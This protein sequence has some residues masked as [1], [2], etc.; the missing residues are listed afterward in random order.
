MAEVRRKDAG[1]GKVQAEGG[2]DDPTAKIDDAVKQAV[3]A[4]EA[5]EKNPAEEPATTSEPKA[6]GSGREAEQPSADEKSEEKPEEKPA[7]KKD[8]EPKKPA[9][10]SAKKP[11]EKAKPAAPVRVRASAKYVRVAPRKARLIAD[12]VRGMHID[13]A[14]ALLAFSPRSAALDIKKLIESAAANAEN[15][16]ELIADEMRV[17]EIRVDEGPII[18]RFRPRA[19]GRATRINKRT[20]HI[21]VA[22]SPEE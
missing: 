19:Q 5:G 6:E 14:R 8:A 22:L 21:S 20:S 1:G 2:G 7:A 11:A 10:K 17:A 16:H 12:Q 3:E 4:S 13:E 9:A 18:K 15:N